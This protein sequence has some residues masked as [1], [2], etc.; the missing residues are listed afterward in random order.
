MTNNRSLSPRFTLLVMVLFI[1]VFFL[2][3]TGQTALLLEGK[4]CKNGEPLNAGREA[5]LTLRIFDDE[6]AGRKL[7]EETQKIKTGAGLTKVTFGQGE[8]TTRKRMSGIPADELWVEVEQDG[9][10]LTPRLALGE[11]GSLNE[12]AAQEFSIQD[13]H[14]RT[15]GAATMVIDNSGIHLGGTLDMGGESIR[16]GGVSRTSWPSGSG[17]SG[18]SDLESRV[19]ALEYKLAHFSRSGNDVYI[20]GANLHIRSGSGSTNGTVNGLGNL[21][22]GYNESRSG[23]EGSDDRTGSHNL[24]LG[25]KQNYSSYG[26]LVAGYLN[27]ISGRYATITGGDHNSAKGHFSVIAGGEHNTT[28]GGD[29]VVAGGYYNR[30]SGDHAS[31]FGGHLNHATGTYCA[32]LGGENNNSKGESSTVTG[33]QMNIANGY[34]CSISGGGFN[35]AKGSS[36][37]I[38]GGSGNETYSSYGVICGG[39]DNQLDSEYASITGGKDNQ[40]TAEYG[41]VTGGKDNVA[42]YKYSSITG[43]QS[44]H[45][46][47]DYECLP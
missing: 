12:L 1:I 8:I 35:T 19:A 45:T 29:S 16:L 11:L 46:T 22:I 42:I 7:Y 33:G 39:S 3:G 38:C 31:I 26:G 44:L 15:S 20:T 18:S 27:A 13:A 17:G 21:I 4:F 9:E 40:V 6:L 24:I 47:K 30:C 5:S 25:R 2:P 32:T 28:E 34:Y 37:S 41:S 36:T 10:V 43:G 14:L 23:S